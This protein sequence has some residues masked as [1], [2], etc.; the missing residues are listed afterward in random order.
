MDQSFDEDKGKK[1]TKIGIAVVGVLLVVLMFLAIYYVA[2]KQTS[3]Y[4]PPPPTPPTTSPTTPDLGSNWT[5]ID[6]SF[7]G[8]QNGVLSPSRLFCCNPSVCPIQH[9]GQPLIKHC[10]A[11][12]GDRPC[13]VSPPPC[14][15][16]RLQ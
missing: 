5:K 6:E 2:T 12:S 4:Q 1:D 15:L 9:C 13:D 14:T 16:I 8:R 3:N 7:C 11:A 10:S